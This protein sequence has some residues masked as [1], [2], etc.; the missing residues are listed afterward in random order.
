MSVNSSMKGIFVEQMTKEVR[1]YNQLVSH[2]K[3]IIVKDKA[4]PLSFEWNFV[5]KGYDNLDLYKHTYNLLIEQCAKNNWLINESSKDFS[6]RLK[7]IKDELQLYKGLNLFPVLRM[8]IYIINILRN[9]KVIWGVGRGSSVA[10]YI[11]Y[12][13]G[14]HDIDSVEYNLDIHEFI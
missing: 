2:D 10:S 14:V 3:R 13:I 12:L 4:R 11:L 1:K 9:N 6:V 7:R 5:E 8:L